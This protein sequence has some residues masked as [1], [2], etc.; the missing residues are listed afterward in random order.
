MC[1]SR[2]LKQFPGLS[3]LLELYLNYL[4]EHWLELL[5]MFRILEA[6]YFLNATFIT[7]RNFYLIRQI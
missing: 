5:L 4:D 7:E 3:V 2:Y 1:I 6:L